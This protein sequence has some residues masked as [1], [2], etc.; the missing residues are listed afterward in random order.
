MEREMG[1]RQRQKSQDD[2][3]RKSSPN[4]TMKRLNLIGACALIATT[5]ACTGAH[6]QPT[7]NDLQYSR[8]MPSGCTGA[9]KTSSDQLILEEC[10][11]NG[12]RPVQPSLTRR[13]AKGVVQLTFGGADSNHSGYYCSTIAAGM[14]TGYSREAFACTASGWQPGR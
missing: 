6:A 12:T 14:P 5:L 4:N 2:P 13:I 8:S 9:R 11:M 7:R 1:P 3:Q 10:T